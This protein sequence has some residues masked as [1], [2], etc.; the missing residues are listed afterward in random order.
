[1]SFN[2]LSFFIFFSGVYLLLYSVRGR[3]PLIQNRLLLAAGGIFYASWDW[4]FLGLLFFTA[5]LDYYCA[6]KITQAGHPGSKKRYLGFSLSGNLLVLGFFK[7][8][9]FFSSSL[10]GLMQ[11]LGFK[12]DPLL[13]SIFLPVGISFYTFQSIGYVLDV[14]RG[15]V[16]PERNFWNYAL[17]VLFFPLLLAGP[18]ERAENLLVQIRRPRAMGEKNFIQGS[19]AVLWGLVKKVVV[20]DRLAIYVNAVFGDIS[21]YSGLTLLVAAY[22]FVFQLYADFS[23]YSDIARGLARI[24]GFQ[25][26]RNF[27][28]PLFAV[29]IQDFWNRWHISLSTWFRDYV[30]TPLFLKLSSFSPLLRLCLAIL[31]TMTMMGLWHGP[32]WHYVAFGVFE[33]F[34]LAV[35]ALVRPWLQRSF[36]PSSWKQDFW[37]A[38]RVFFMFQIT[39]V[40]LL[41]FRVNRLK[42]I[43]EVFK[44]IFLQP[45]TLF[46]AG[47]FRE[48]IL[49]GL[50][51]IALLLLIENPKRSRPDAEALEVRSGTLRWAF[52]T[53]A[54][55][56]IFLFGVYDGASFIYF[57]F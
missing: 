43:G 37:F 35:Y 25:V 36:K 3:G 44:K 5:C 8:F 51:G 57:R 30:F 31:G 14:Y 33:G 27:N 29:N 41:F 4:R 10:A 22:F 12:A 20:A 55:F 56:A 45:G 24:L 21:K 46:F 9:N 26:M 13:L 23:G 18:I 16:P 49:Y 11:G 50:I 2:S 19:R 15:K 53:A 40:G 48:S 32:A 52:Y 38:A 42:A 47:D 7:Y 34:L 17:Y 54:I 28:L 39:T 6:L 1:M